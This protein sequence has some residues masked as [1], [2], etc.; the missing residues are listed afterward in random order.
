MEFLEIFSKIKRC[1]KF[2]KKRKDFEKFIKIWRFPDSPKF[3]QNKEKRFSNTG[4]AK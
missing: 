1:S 2:K 4:P 3:S